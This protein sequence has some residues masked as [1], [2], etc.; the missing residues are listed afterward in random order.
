MGQSSSI[1]L[2]PDSPGV[3]RASA[4]P[5]HSAAGVPLGSV[6][7]PPGRLFSRGLILSDAAMFAST[8]AY[9]QAD[10]RLRYSGKLWTGQS[11]THEYGIHLGAEGALAAFEIWLKRKHRSTYDQLQGLPAVA[12]F[13][14]IAFSLILLNAHAYKKGELLPTTPISPP[15]IAP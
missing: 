12:A 1:R 8:I 13:G 5:E 11:R 4:L 2:L 10:Y 14:N 3:S 6:R 7:P 15:P 9:V